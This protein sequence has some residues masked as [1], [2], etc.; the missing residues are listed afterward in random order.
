M[1]KLLSHMAVICAQLWF[2]RAI[3]S[4]VMLFSCKIL[5]TLDICVY[6]EALI[7]LCEYVKGKAATNYW[8]NQKEV[9]LGF[10]LP[11]EALYLRS[12]VPNAAT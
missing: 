11:K 3:V 10:E 6:T 9:Y 2:C 12:C 5:C 1:Q 8:R 7:V 4:I